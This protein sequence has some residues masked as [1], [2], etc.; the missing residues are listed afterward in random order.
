MPS[1]T[2]RLGSA[3]AWDRLTPSWPLL[4]GLAAFARA[5]TDPARLLADPDTYL[6]IAAGRWMLAHLALPL[7]DPFSHSMVGAAW[8]PH[9]WLAEIALAAAFAL[10]GWSGVVMLVAASFAIAAALL[11]RL[12]LSRLDPL[13]ALVAT[14]AGIALLMPHLLARPHLLALPLLVVWCGRLFAARDDDRAPSLWLLAVMALWANLHASFIFGLALAGFLAVE[15][16]LS[17]GPGETRRVVARRWGLFLLA[18][19][20]AALVT[21]YG[22]A[23]LVQPFRLMAMPGLQSTFAEW[24]SPD[25]RNAPALELWILGATFIGF[26][27]GVRLPLTRALLLTGLVHMT[28]QHARHEDLLAIVGPLAAAAPLGRAFAISGA[29]AGSSQLRVWFTRLALPAAAPACLLALAVALALSLPMVLHPIA[30]A[31]DPVTPGTALAAADRLGL[32]GPVYN[33]EAF[34]GY[35]LFRGVPSFIDGRV[36]LYGDAFVTEDFQ[37]ENGKEA[38]LTAL[39]ARYRI[40]W[41]LL[42]PQAGAVGVLDRLPGWQRV[43]ADDQ[44]VI[45]R[46]VDFAAR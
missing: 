5:V 7:A 38:A 34:G 23:G 39:L 42:L 28:L 32:A 43:Y 24:L 22:P 44:A 12:L 3:V 35:L 21:P 14:V 37:A 2:R 15:A 27:S 10:G 30:R 16:V 45:H 46:R 18:A 19:V 31:D 8:L 6:H 13:A 36:E 40:G 25:F 17:P 26:A 29:S 1:R 33:S 9:E 4:L 41:T 20:T 11:L